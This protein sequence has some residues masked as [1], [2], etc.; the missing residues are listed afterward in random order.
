MI[1]LFLSLTVLLMSCWTDLIDY[2][3]AADDETNEDQTQSFSDKSR[4]LPQTS[5]STE[6]SVFSSECVR[7]DTNLNVHEDIQVLFS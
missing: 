2:H 4:G 5:H 3:S 1:F 7:V 6:Q